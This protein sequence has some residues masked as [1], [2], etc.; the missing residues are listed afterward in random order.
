MPIA[1]CV[2]RNRFIAPWAHTV[3]VALGEERRNKAIA[4]YDPISSRCGG[5]ARAL[6]RIQGL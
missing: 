2:G 4:P 3:S 1:E 5:N 6:L